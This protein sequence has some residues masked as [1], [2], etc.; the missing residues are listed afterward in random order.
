MKRF[1]FIIISFL[2]FLPFS[3][4]AQEVLG[5]SKNFN[6]EA[7]YDFY[8]R[9]Q[10]TA[11]LIKI[12]P[13]VYWYMDDSWWKEIGS[14]KKEEIEQSLNALSEEF[15]INIYSILTGVFGS[16][17]S[18]GIDKDTRITV[19]I[20]QMKD[21][22]GGY[23]DTTDEYPK[24]QFPDSNEREM[25]YLN[26][27]YI[28]TN[29]A[30]VFLAHELVHLITFNQKDKKYN[31]SEDIWLNEARADYSSTLLGYDDDYKESNLQR[32]VKDFLNKPSDSLTEWRETPADYGIAHLFIQYLVDH[33]GIQILADSLKMKETGIESLNAFLYQKGFKEDFAEIFN[34]WTIAVLINNCDVSEKY[35]YFNKNLKD[36]RITSLINYLPF[37]GKSTLS[38]TNTTKDWAGNW[39][40]FIGG[41]GTLKLEFVKD[42]KIIFKVF[43]I[44]EDSAG[45]VIINSLEFNG[46][47]RGE[48]FIPDFGSKNIS[49]TIIPVAQNKT[50]NFMKIESS[51]SFFWSVSTQEEEE[52]DISLPPIEKP[53]SEMTREELL[54]RIAQL[55]TILLQ[56]QAQLN[57]LLG[58]ETTCQEISQNLY[59][60]MHNDSQ[61]RCLQE[62]LKSQGSEIYP[63]GLVTGNFLALTQQAVIRFQEKYSAEILTPLGLKKGT[64]YVGLRT[65]LKINELL[66]S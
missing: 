24:L 7:S 15:E 26:A 35:C 17:W 22:T 4:N 20:H 37:I 65:R 36:F 6:V 12:S 31:A 61:V 1:L 8:Q 64:G 27:Q 49:L 34:N 33:Y 58:I 9:S 45:N 25:I 47:Q 21:E 44:I 14:E 39:H 5:Q 66:A 63:E 59:S 32:R 62:F 48:I 57:K 52:V 3:G 40:K 46:N 23:N 50:S 2:I 42:S 43:Y 16:E 10:I 41:K 51:Y 11:T 30:K 13:T 55:Q 56:L 54:G 28:N 29:N 60:G 38:V 19:L 53:V 18:P